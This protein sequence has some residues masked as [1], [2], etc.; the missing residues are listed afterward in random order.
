M[1]DGYPPTSEIVG[2]ERALEKLQHA[3][4]TSN[5]ITVVGPPGVGKTTLV[6]HFVSQKKFAWV[7]VRP[8]SISDLSDALGKALGGPVELSGVLRPNAD[9]VVFDAA[10][11]ALEH[12]R[13][14]TEKLLES[15][16][17]VLIASRQ[18]VE[19]LNEHVLDLGPLSPRDARALFGRLTETDDADEDVDT[20]IDSLDGLPLAIE[21]AAGRASIMTPGQMNVRLERRFDWLRDLRGH[22][23]SLVDVIEASWNAL[24]QRA[25]DVLVALTS[26]AA[27]F[28]LTSAECVAPD[29]AGDDAVVNVLERLV[30]RS[31]VQRVG[32]SFRLL[33]SI[34]LF[35]RNAAPELAELATRRHADYFT[36][37]DLSLRDMFTRMPLRPAECIAE[38]VAIRKRFPKN[39][40]AT[41]LW[42]IAAQSAMV[43]RLRAVSELSAAIATT[44]EADLQLT[45]RFVRGGFYRDA[46]RLDDALSDLDAVVNNPQAWDDLRA[47]AWGELVNIHGVRRELDRAQTAAENALSIFLATGDHAAVSKVHLVFGHAAYRSGFIEKAKLETAKALEYAE[48]HELP[49]TE[50][51]VN[52]AGLR[53]AMGDLEGAIALTDR[54]LADFGK[55][56]DRLT[57]LC[58]NNRGAAHLA[59]GDLDAA[60]ADLRASL[61]INR[62]IGRQQSERIGSTSMAL[63]SLERKSTATAVAYAERAR[64][65]EPDDS[66]L[67]TETLSVLALTSM[68]DKAKAADYLRT[69]RHV[70]KNDGD[71]LFVDMVEAIAD[72]RDLPKYAPH[73]CRMPGFS[74]LIKL[75]RTARPA[76]TFS[77]EN[78]T[79]TVNGVAHDLRRRG[80]MK[81]TLQRLMEARST[82]SHVDVYD[83]F[84]AGWPGEDVSPE[85]AA[86][87]VYA[88]LSRL[89]Q[90]GLADIIVTVDDGYTLAT[91]IGET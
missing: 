73:Y 53:L 35:A 22:K 34:R 79:L 16:T 77:A 21:L 27:D 5:V 7:G 47:R 2:R 83:L 1:S 49:V 24:P 45:F 64:A 17:K 10:E 62:R 82:R 69:A 58:L 68:P 71:H 78:Q 6:S 20:L 9:V 56:N 81:R 65:G 32:S 91:D 46:G 84:D 40:R 42:G 87:R 38:L 14:W 33:D 66:R 52:V 41:L 4:E 19:C 15:K 89:R 8:G 25:R 72:G 12:V 70:A 28:S 60:E 29:A 39:Q 55:A 30:R 59:L 85:Q 54:C 76:V 48:A 43:P 61:E 57:G 75:G 90:L 63:L 50:I 37:A 18:P 36:M 74:T 88:T 11:H 86:N 13:I 26:F 51:L 80:A 31:L 23:P 3:F 44:T 67:G